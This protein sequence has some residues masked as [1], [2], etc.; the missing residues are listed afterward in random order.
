MIHIYQFSDF[1]KIS[2]AVMVEIVFWNSFE[3]YTIIF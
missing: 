3:I 1:F 2:L